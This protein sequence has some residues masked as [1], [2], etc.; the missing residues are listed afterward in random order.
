MN[1]KMTNPHYIRD[2][3]MPLVGFKLNEILVVPFEQKI[4]FCYQLRKETH[5]KGIANTWNI[6][7]PS[8]NQKLR[9]YSFINE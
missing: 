8:I 5:R 7:V 1:S 6:N 4:S 2:K 3:T 9:Q